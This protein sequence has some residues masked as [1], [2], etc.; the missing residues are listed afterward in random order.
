[1][2]RILKN[3]R[4]LI[5]VLAL[6]NQAMAADW[7]DLTNLYITNPNYEG[8]SNQGWT[9]EAWAGSTKCEYGCQEFWQGIWDYY[10]TVT[11]PDGHYR[12]SVTGYHRPTTYSST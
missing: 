8:N 5:L 1:M 6:S 11:I 2:K 9:M 10:Q 7:I 3:I 4:N 12:I